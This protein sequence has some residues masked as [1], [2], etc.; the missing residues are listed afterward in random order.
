MALAAFPWELAGTK[1]KGP[2]ATVPPD[3]VVP[4]PVA[5]SLRN[6]QF[7]WARRCKLCG[8]VKVRL[9]RGIG[10]TRKCGNALTYFDGTRDRKQRQ[11]LARIG[12]QAR[13]ARARNA[14]KRIERRVRHLTPIEA[15][16]LAYDRGY[17]AGHKAGRGGYERLPKAS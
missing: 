7:L 9:A 13:T 5:Q 8:R 11:H 10:C 14:E 17:Q 2:A 15:Y 3:A 1:R 12:E 16:R 4:F 6:R